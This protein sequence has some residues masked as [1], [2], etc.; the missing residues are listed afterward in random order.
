MCMQPIHAAI[1]LSHDAS[2]QEIPHKMNE[3]VVNSSC[4]KAEALLSAKSGNIPAVYIASWCV[5]RHTKPQDVPT[6]IQV[7][8]L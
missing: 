7:A 3:Q 4:L 6:C 8:V 5:D 2:L 1:L